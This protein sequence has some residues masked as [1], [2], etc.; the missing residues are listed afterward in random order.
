MTNP[1]DDEQGE[2]VALI[3]KED[4]YSLWP[5]FAEVPDGWSITHGPA[6]RR[7]CLEYIEKSWIDMRPTSLIRAMGHDSA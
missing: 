6:G 7:E 1:F 5:N 2:F 4:Q 3:N